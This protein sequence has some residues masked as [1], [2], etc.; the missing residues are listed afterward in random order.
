MWLVT[1]KLD[2]VAGVKLGLLTSLSLLFG[3]QEI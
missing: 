2:N 3:V 1:T